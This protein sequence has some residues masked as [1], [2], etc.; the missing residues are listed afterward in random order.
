MTTTFTPTTALCLLGNLDPTSL[1]GIVSSSLTSSCW[2]KLSGL[3]SG[4]YMVEYLKLYLTINAS[5]SG[6]TFRVLLPSS[7]TYDYT[8][9]AGAVS[10]ANLT[11]EEGGTLDA[12][13]LATKT[14]SAASSGT[15]EVT[16]DLS[17]VTRVMGGS[18]WAGK[19][20]FRVVPYGTCDL[21][22]SLDSSRPYF[23][24]AG[25]IDYP[26]RFTGNRG[27][28]SSRWSNCP[29]TGQRVPRGEMVLD[30][31]RGILVHPDNYDPPEPDPVE[32]GD[33]IPDPSE[34]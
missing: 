10:S 32:F 19:L 3:S 24:T 17:E 28:Q 4:L 20:N 1:N 6:G 18:G 25:T 21:N 30:G 7:S 13:V 27:I 8:F 16:L 5:S 12:L 2:L 22:I 15:I 31:Y 11:P 23:T 14:F 33:D 29:I 26:N 9:S 34:E